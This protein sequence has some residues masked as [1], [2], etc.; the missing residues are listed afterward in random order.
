MPLAD[1]QFQL[2]DG[3]TFGRASDTVKLLAG[4]WDTGT[5]ELRVQ[6]VDS[7][8]A[9]TRAFGRDWLSPPVWTLSLVIL[10][11]GGGASYEADRF[12]AWWRT[13]ARRT[14][15]SLSTL[16][17]GIGGKDF[18]VYGRPGKVSRSSLAAGDK[19]V[20]IVAEFRLQEALAYGNDEQVVTLGLTTPTSGGV[21]LPAVAPLVLAGPAGE[22]AGIINVGGQH[23]APVVVQ[24][25]GPATGQALNPVVEVVGE[26]SIGL[27]GAVSAGQTVIVDT[28]RRTVTRNGVD[29]PGLLNSTSSLRSRLPRGVLEV[30][31]RAVDPSATSS[32]TFRFRDTY[33][34]P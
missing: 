21:V 2:D 29:T 33:P 16:R 6:D 32:A 34:C 28:L 7:P 1:F 31:Y 13:S 19:R 17:Y 26:W 14:L 12:I 23:L 24:F 27:T 22:R 18:L 10:K 20:A 30:K 5:T 8:R 4:G 9:D 11:P 15:G 25:N 3:E